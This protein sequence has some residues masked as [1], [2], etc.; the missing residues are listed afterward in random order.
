MELNRIYL[1][2]DFSNTIVPVGQRFLFLGYYDGI[3]G[4]EIVIRY[5]DSDGNFGNIASGSSGKNEIIE[6]FYPT[7]NKTIEFENTKFPCGIKTAT[8]K[9]FPI[10]P[11]TLSEVDNKFVIDLTN[12]LVLADEEFNSNIQY[13][14]Y[15]SVGGIK[16]N[17]GIGIAFKGAYSNST[18]YSCE[19]G[20]SDAVQYEGSL[21]GYVNSTPTAGNLPPTLPQISNEYWSL[22]VR[23]GERGEQNSQ[24]IEINSLTNG[25]IEVETNSIPVFIKTSI[26]NFYPVEKDTLIQFE[27]KFYIEVEPYLAYD[28]VEAFSG[29]WR[30]YLG[31]GIKGDSLTYD[32]V[33]VFADR[34]KYDDE[35]YKFSFLATDQGMI[36]IKLSDNN[37]D[38]SEGIEVKGRKGEDGQALEANYID[39]TTTVD[40]F[41]VVSDETIPVSVEINNA[42][43]PVLGMIKENNTFKI[44]TAPILASANI[45]SYSGIWRVWRAGGKQ[46]V[47]G[48]QGINGGTFPIALVDALPENPD[49]STL[50]LIPMG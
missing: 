22:L 32:E 27:N 47:D 26:G 8:G 6:Y 45:A 16:G 38:W 14:V 25:K 9:I 2:S 28:N 7:E 33:G 15:I 23:K 40:G 13:G 17:D 21:W 37:G 29:T 39:V 49:P 1:D 50:Y 20:I 35:P 43:F 41:L 30:V 11:E 4:S 48:E 12:Y 44:P 10:L 34:S 3:E 19:N 31:G 24:Y 18:T 36:Y 46:G 5:K 42:V